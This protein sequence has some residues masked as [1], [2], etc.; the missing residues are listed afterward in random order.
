MYE[1]NG[2]QTRSTVNTCALEYKQ[3][4]VC[5]GC[6][7]HWNEKK[8]KN[9]R[10]NHEED[11]LPVRNFLDICN[12]RSDE[13]NKFEL[14]FCLVPFIFSWIF[15]VPCPMVQRFNMIMTTDNA[16]CISSSTPEPLTVCA[17][18]VLLNFPLFWLCKIAHTI[19][20]F[21]WIE[22]TR[23]QFDYYAHCSF[24]PE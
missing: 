13:I 15:S 20:G 18:C 22:I 21:M 9:E 2:Y 6:C 4:Q 19:H 23:R 17:V 11:F 5:Y 16:K 14:V 10:N 24:L 7:G 1:S 12:I 8:I 3:D